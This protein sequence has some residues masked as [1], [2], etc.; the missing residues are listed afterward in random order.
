PRGHEPFL[1][2]SV[3]GL[4]SGSGASAAKA[5][6]ARWSTESC[7]TGTASRESWCSTPIDLT[8]GF[9]FGTARGKLWEQTSKHR[10]L[11]LQADRIHCTRT[12]EVPRP[13]ATCGAGLD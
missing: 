4:I 13:T 9:H 11:R 12:R 2:S 6:V 8:G 3:P 7:T 10:G 1:A 5:A